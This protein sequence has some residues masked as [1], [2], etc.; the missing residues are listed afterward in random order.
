M[1]KKRVSNYGLLFYPKV[2]SKYKIPVNHFRGLEKNLVLRRKD[3]SFWF[4]FF[5]LQKEKQCQ[6]YS[7]NQFFPNYLSR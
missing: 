2:R 4:V 6:K 1:Y 5:S 7:L 3:P